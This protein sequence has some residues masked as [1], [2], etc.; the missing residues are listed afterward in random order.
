MDSQ[1]IVEDAIRDGSTAGTHVLRG[2]GI[3]LADVEETDANEDDRVGA[4]LAALPGVNL[5]YRVLKDWQQECSPRLYGDTPVLV[6]TTRQESGR[7]KH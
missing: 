7:S 1:A 5:A 4:M 3:A 2:P 6:K